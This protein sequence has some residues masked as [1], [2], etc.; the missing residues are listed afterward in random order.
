MDLQVRCAVPILWLAAKS[1][2]LGQTV[3]HEMR[4]RFPDAIVECCALVDDLLSATGK[5]SVLPAGPA[6]FIAAKFFWD[7][8]R[9]LI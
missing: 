2:L 3:W 7:E 8:M 5:F 4:D 9:P 6:G 1:P